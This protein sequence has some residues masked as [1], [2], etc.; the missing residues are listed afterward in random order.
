MKKGSFSR[1]F[2]KNFTKAWV[3]S[4]R[5]SWKIKGQPAGEGVRREIL[6][7]YNAE[8]GLKGKVD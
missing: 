1:R 3:A 7:W 6:G 2:G 4:E 8:L 5:P